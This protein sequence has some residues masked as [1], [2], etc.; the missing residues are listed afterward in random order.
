MDSYVN[1]YT[2][3]RAYIDIYQLCH[4]YLFMFSFPFIASILFP[5][6]GVFCSLSLSH[7][8]L[9]FPLSFFCWQVYTLCECLVKL[10]RNEEMAL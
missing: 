2:S 7:V 1:T 4:R 6:D 8:D 9:M 5:S 3:Y 10:L